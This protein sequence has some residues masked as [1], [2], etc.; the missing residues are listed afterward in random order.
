MTF[1]WPTRTNHSFILKFLSS[2]I[3]NRLGNLSFKGNSS[4]QGSSHKN[5]SSPIPINLLCFI[6]IQFR[7]KRHIPFSIFWM[8]FHQIEQTLIS[9]MILLFA[10]PYLFAKT[11]YHKLFFSTRR[12]HYHFPNNTK[13][14]AFKFLCLTPFFLDT[15]S[16]WTQLIFLVVSHLPPL[17]FFK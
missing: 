5:V 13:L 3:L 11:L 17:E 6:D 12:R 2:Q 1:L 15:L 9:L 8:S 14:K 4:H 10:S 7:S 16:H